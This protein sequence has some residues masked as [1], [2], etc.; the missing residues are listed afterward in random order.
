MTSFST[1]LKEFFSARSVEIIQGE[2]AITTHKLVFWE[3][4]QLQNAQLAIGKETNINLLHN[5]DF[6]IGHNPPSLS[7]KMSRPK[8]G[9]YEEQLFKATVKEHL[10]FLERVDSKSKAIS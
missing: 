4:K 1:K 6:S 7:I 8:E 5:D 3:E 10:R 9:Y 2:N